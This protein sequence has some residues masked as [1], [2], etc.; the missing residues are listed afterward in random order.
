MKSQKNLETK[1]SSAKVQP[2]QVDEC[3]MVFRLVAWGNQSR[4]GVL[5]TNWEP[6]NRFQPTTVAAS[7]SW[8]THGF[9]P[10]LLSLLR[11]NMQMKEAN[12]WNLKVAI[13]LLWVLCCLITKDW[14][15]LA[16]NMSGNKKR[17]R[18]VSSY[19]YTYIQYIHI[20][21]YIDIL[22]LNKCLGTCPLLQFIIHLSFQN[23]YYQS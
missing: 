19:I 1:K 14:H 20:H 7:R 18:A 22:Y 4:W 6:P 9:E 10:I 13:G 8:K 23:F 16:R 15:K 2:V 3:Y 11:L 17:W 21:S 5:P 12:I